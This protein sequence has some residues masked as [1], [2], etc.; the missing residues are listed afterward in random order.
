VDCKFLFKKSQW[1]IL[2][3]NKNL[4]GIIYLDLSF[5]QPK[6]CRLHSATVS[7]TLDD[8]DKELRELGPKLRRR[9]S[10]SQ[11]PIQMTDCYG[12]KGFA[13]PERTV[14]RKKSLHLAPTGQFMGYGFGG[15]GVETES[16][17]AYSS[18]WRFSGHLLPG[19]G[20]DWA[21]KTLKWDLVENDL[22]NQSMHK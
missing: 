18:R 21:Y 8:E 1:G 14:L 10:D 3:E 9:G 13:G 16:S 17:S 11:C 4:A 19:K 22:E 6:G 20:N 12:P 2:G 7:V 15:V 5:R